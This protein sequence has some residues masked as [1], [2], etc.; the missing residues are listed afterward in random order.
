MIFIDFNFERKKTVHYR[1]TRKRRLNLTVK[2][3]KNRFKNV[4]KN[5]TKLLTRLPFIP[6]SS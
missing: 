1:K 4:L 6:S 5:V 2:Y 3:V